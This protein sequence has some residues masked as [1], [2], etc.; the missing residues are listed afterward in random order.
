MKTMGRAAA[1]V[2]KEKRK[3]QASGSD[4]SEDSDITQSLRK[5]TRQIE[6]EYLQEKDLDELKSINENA[7]A[8]IVETKN[9]FPVF[10]V[11]VSV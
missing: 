8:K 11:N 7:L 5:K 3:R 6:K 4:S 9:D 10:F 2:I 1:S